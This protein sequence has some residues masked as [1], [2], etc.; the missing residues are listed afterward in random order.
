[1]SSQLALIMDEEVHLR[2]ASDDLTEDDLEAL[3]GVLGS[4]ANV[5][6]LCDSRN[7]DER[8]GLTAEKKQALRQEAAAE[9]QA[10]PALRGEWVDFREKG[11]ITK[12]TLADLYA[13]VITGDEKIRNLDFAIK[14]L[15]AAL[16]DAR[17]PVKYKG[18]PEDKEAKDK[19]PRAIRLAIAAVLGAKDRE[20]QENLARVPGMIENFYAARNRQRTRDMETILNR[21][22]APYFK[23]PVAKH[24]GCKVSDLK[25]LFNRFQNEIVAVRGALK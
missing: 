14:T 7:E 1:M 4:S 21:L 13:L 5:L 17:V 23:G 9:I 19:E 24:F 12:V 2:L 20:F 18:E 8:Q 15:I 11:K 6:A 16:K 25:H 3:V 10:I 22:A